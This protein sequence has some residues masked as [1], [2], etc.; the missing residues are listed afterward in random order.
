MKILQL[1]VW[2]GKIE[3]NLK[4]FLQE[5]DFDIICLQEVFAS[6]DCQGHPLRAFAL[7][8]RKSLK[9]AVSNMSFSRLIGAVI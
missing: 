3:G 4:R 6:D 5:N 7:T 1:N 8:Y 2:M 9:Q